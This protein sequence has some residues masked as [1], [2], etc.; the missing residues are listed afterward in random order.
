MPYTI[1]ERRGSFSQAAVREN[2]LYLEALRRLLITYSYGASV[3]LYSPSNLNKNGIIHVPLG[4]MQTKNTQF[5]RG[6]IEGF[7]E[8][9]V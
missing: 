1:P 2:S 8:N 5:L 9:S 3:G 6:S 4:F 7:G